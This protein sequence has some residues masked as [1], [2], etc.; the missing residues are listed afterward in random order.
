M[1]S[2]ISIPVRI[3]PTGR[4]VISSEDD[5]ADKIVRLALSSGDND[6]A[7]QQDISLG[8][9]AVFA[10]KDPGFR[11]KTVARLIR[12][13]GRFESEKRFKLIRNSIKW[14]NGLPG[15]SVLRL[16]YQN[17]ETDQVVDYAQSFGQGGGRTS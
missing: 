12:I 7:F 5:Q 10:K 4:T 2:G 6:N 1:A 11:A 3:G 13:F 16:K 9:D 14:E 17:L 8:E 15:E